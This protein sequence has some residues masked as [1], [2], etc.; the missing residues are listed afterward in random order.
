MKYI[1]LS[2]HLDDVALSCGGLIRKQ[3]KLNLHVEIWTICAGDPPEGNLSPFAQTMHKK[4]KSKSHPVEQRR[5]EDKT[6][7]AILGAIPRYFNISDCI[8]R[9]GKDGKNLYDSE[10]K[11]FNEIHPDDCKM[12]EELTAEID[13]LLPRD[14][15]LISPLS[16]GQHVDHQVTR[17]IAEALR[18]PLWFYADYPYAASSPL[19]ISLKPHGFQDLRFPISEG[20]LH[21]WQDAVAAY[22]SQISTFWLDLHDM[23]K[24]IA[25]YCKQEAGV[26]IWGNP[27]M[28]FM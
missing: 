26:R 17:R 5:Q 18:Y 1:Y 19:M 28:F 2:P 10:E 9:K 24:D 14:F 20:E 6:S 23:K 11:L 13:C 16:I 3:T 22:K 15:R 25:G 4:W 7:C 8:Y 27:Q 12:I 21:K